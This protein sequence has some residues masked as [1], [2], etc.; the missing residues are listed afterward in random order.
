MIKEGRQQGP[1]WETLIHATFMVGT[2]PLDKIA[3]HSYS[4]ILKNRNPEK[5]KIRPVILPITANIASTRKPRKTN[6]GRKD[7]YDNSCAVD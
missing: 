1:P 7:W 6:N 4:L 5:H 3:L 2:R